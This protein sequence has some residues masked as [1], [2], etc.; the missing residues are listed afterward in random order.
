LFSNFGRSR[1]QDN[2]NEEDFF[3]PRILGAGDAVEGRTQIKNRSS[4]VYR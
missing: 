1:P 2:I 3:A 4:F